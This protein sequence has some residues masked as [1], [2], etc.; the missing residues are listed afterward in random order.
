MLHLVFKPH[1]STLRAQ[2]ADAQKLFVLLKVIPGA[3]LGAH[4]PPLALAF[5]VD[6]SGSMREAGAKDADGRASSKLDVAIKATQN[7]LG[8]ARLVEGDLVSVIQFDD[9]ARVV[10]PLEPLGDRRAAT[11][12]LSRLSAYNGGTQIA[13]G[14]SAAQNELARI[15]QA[16]VAQRVLLLTDGQAFDE[17]ACHVAAKALADADVPLVAIGIGDDYNEELLRDL[18]EIGRG[19][20]YHLSQI[21]GLEEV[22]GIEVA[23]S[24]REVVTGLRARVQT[25]AGV[26]L[27]GVTRVYPDLAEMKVDDSSQGAATVPLG[28]ISAGDYTVFVLEMTVSGRARAAG[29]ARLAQVQLFGS[30]SNRPGEIE[31][32]SSEL[33]VSFSD[34]D[35][36]AEEVSDEV[37]G[38]VEQRNVDRLVQNAVKRAQNDVPGAQKSLRI[39]LDITRRLGNVR[40]TRMLQQS[41]DELGTRGKMSA[42]TRKTVMLETRTRTVKTT[43]ADDLSEVPGDDDIHRLTGA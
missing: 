22:F 2:T 19:R 23:S 17:Q 8:D 43:V 35:A 42:S 20:P 36:D 15:L 7:A 38:Y 6:S 12:A 40:A 32:Q 1:R 21:E 13:K 39:A 25:V 11:A 18:A 9:V 30:V 31:S 24:A 33:V 26:S 34:H 4:R 41:L 28:N 27:G 5:V 10:L 37:L 3:T 14:L 16:G 29:R